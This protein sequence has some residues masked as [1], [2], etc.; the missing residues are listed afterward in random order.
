MK[1]I[2][3]GLSSSNIIQELFSSFAARWAPNDSARSLF[4]IWT[5]PSHKPI[6][7]LEIRCLHETFSEKD[8]KSLMEHIQ[9]MASGEALLFPTTLSL[10]FDELVERAFTKHIPFGSNPGKFTWGQSVTA[11]TPPPLRASTPIPSIASSST[12][13]VIPPSF[14][15]APTPV[16]GPVSPSTTAP[17]VWLKCCRCGQPAR[18]QDLY[19]G[20]RCPQCPPRGKKGRPFMQCQLCNAA[21]VMHSDKCT[22]KIC[23]RTFV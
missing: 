21:R 7:D 18:S 14:L 2:Q 9:R 23:Q 3:S 8:P 16:P 15:Q 19:E 1:S 4:P 11:P 17:L 20:L 10:V 13:C 12:P 22:R 5:F 6:L